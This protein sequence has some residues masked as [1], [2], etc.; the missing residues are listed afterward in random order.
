[1]KKI[2]AV[3]GCPTGI[4]HTFMAEEALKNAAKELGIEIK[5]ETNG[6]AG[7]ENELTKKDIEEAIGVIVASDKH[8]DVERFNGKP[9]IETSVQDG[10]RRPKELI[11]KILDGNVPIRK[12][13]VKFTRKEEE[14]Q[15]V[16]RQIYRHLMNGVSNMLPFVVAGGVL[17][18]VSFF[19]G[20]YSADPNS[21]QYNEI[22]AMLNAIGGHAFGL[23]VPIF[24]AFIAAS[25]SNRPG[26][27]AG[28]IGGIIANETG[29][30]FLG[31]I[32]A[33]F[34]AGY[35]M[36]WLTKVLSRLPREFEGL[37]SIFLLPLLGVLLTGTLMTILGKPV[38]QINDSMMN[39]LSS[40]QNANPILLG[41]VIGCMSAFDFGGPVNKAAYVTGTILLGQGNYYFMAGV[42]A[43]CITPPLIIALATT[44]FKQEFTQDERAAGLVNYILGFTHITEGAIPFAAKDPLRVIPIL[45]IGS[46]VS[47]ILTYM[48]HVQVPAP[49]G[50]F[51]ILPLVTKPFQ[52]VL[53]IFVGSITGAILYGLYRRN[54]R[55]KMGEML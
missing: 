43:A 40:L 46:S 8:V 41:I 31:G 39:W 44:I 48:M 28:F 9:V 45:M 2:I 3:T 55:R 30:G 17:I 7:V 6:A 53:A 52:W 11:Q 19:W 37:K 13:E 26:M 42:S 18:A 21:E 24:T 25:I 47:S 27:I 1:M 32:I 38:A 29:A 50:G 35:F 4:A 12:D 16:G 51:L 36:L 23:M 49:H 54:R 5:V 15:S 20:I 33:G 10:I 14:K 22:A 34:F